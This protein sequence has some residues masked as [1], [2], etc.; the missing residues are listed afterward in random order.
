MIA[1][2]FELWN[3]EE[4]TGYRWQLILVGA[5]VVGKY[6][7]TTRRSCVVAV[8]NFARRHFRCP[9]KIRNTVTEYYN[10]DFLL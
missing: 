8:Q 7:Y 4:I 1:R 6:T 10:T 3:D 5:V 9:V 2:I